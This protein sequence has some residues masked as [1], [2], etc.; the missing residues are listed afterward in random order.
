MKPA[1]DQLG[2]EFAGSSSVLIGDAD[3]T[4][5]GESLC[6]DFDVQGFPTVKY[7]V[8]GDMK[9]EKYSGARDYDSLLAFVQET[10]EVKCD[11]KNS[12]GCTDKEKE[13]IDKMKAKSSDE[14]VKQIKRLE[15]M[16][17]DPMKAELKAWLRQRLHILNMLEA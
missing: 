17:F 13:Y 3:C 15:G 11:V 9:G 14:R 8:D 16:A 1:W 10:L 7:F 6:N 5:S 2:E 4:G 12:E